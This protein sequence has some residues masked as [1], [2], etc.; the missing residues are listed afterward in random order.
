[1]YEIVCDQQTQLT[2]FES[3][4]SERVVSVIASME[5]VRGARVNCRSSLRYLIIDAQ[6]HG[7]LFRSFVGDSVKAATL[8]Q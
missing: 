2:S 4:M 7:D 1:M 8:E 6:E 3:L 5:F